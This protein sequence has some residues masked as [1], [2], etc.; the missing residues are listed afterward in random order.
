MGEEFYSPILKERIRGFKNM[1]ED[2]KRWNIT[3]E[4]ACNCGGIMFY[5]P[6]FAGKDY[7]M[8][9]KCGKV[10]DYL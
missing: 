4:Q 6:S 7:W 8:C 3:N 5:K 9:S 10:E 1:T 2:E